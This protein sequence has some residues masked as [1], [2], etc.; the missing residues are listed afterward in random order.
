MFYS[1]L[2][3]KVKEGKIDEL[4]ESYVF[5]L[6]F[7]AYHYFDFSSNFNTFFVDYL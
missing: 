1:N 4:K 2:V 7:T 3:T 5:R 6:N